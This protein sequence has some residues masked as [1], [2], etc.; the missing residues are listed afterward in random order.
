VRRLD[1]ASCRTVFA[2]GSNRVSG[3][4]QRWFCSPLVALRESTVPKSQVRKKKVY[5]PPTDIRPAAA[6]PHNKPSPGWLPGSALARMVF[7]L[8]WVVGY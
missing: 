5:T 4:A 8:S 3:A 2:T 6:A 7:G 1:Y